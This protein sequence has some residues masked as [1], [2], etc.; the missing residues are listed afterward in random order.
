MRVLLRCDATP[1]I[2]AGRL[3]RGLAIAEALVARGHEALLSGEVHEQWA[4][5]L[6]QESGLTLL[7]AP[8]TVED[9]LALTVEHGPQIVHVDAPDGRTTTAGLEGAG[10][11]LSRLEDD[12]IPDLV[13][14]LLVAPVF[15]GVRNPGTLDHDPGGQIVAAGPEYAPMRAAVIEA[16]ERRQ[17]RAGG[18]G[19]RL[20]VLVR[21]GD[22]ETATAMLPVVLALANSDLATDVLVVAVSP[23]IGRRAES[24]STRQ[25]RVLATTRRADLPRLI[26]D[27][28]LVVTRP[29]PIMWEL[30]CIGTPVALVPLTADEEADAAHWVA[31]EVAV[32]LGRPDAEFRPAGQLRNLLRDGLRRAQMGTNGLHLVDGEGAARVATLIELVAAR[33]PR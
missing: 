3:L 27:H 19:D 17:W 31:A 14:D 13:A 25:V 5:E 26:A 18:M 32:N 8:A 23:T 9:L 16:R 30:C 7:P 10:V 20:R 6:L 28:D 11:R 29:G 22:D 15:D 21:L 4:R 33:P 2:G 24:L 1:A 12:G